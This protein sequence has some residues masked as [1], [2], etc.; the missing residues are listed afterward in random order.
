MPERIICNTMFTQTASQRSDGRYSAVLL[1]KRPV[2]KRWHLF[3]QEIQADTQEDLNQAIA[4]FVGDDPIE[5]WDAFC[6]RTVIAA[7]RKPGE[8]WAHA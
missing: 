1:L 7:A 8:R 3:S 6:A 5:D 2:G 4:T